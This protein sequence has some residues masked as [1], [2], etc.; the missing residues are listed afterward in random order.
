MVSLTDKWIDK[1]GLALYDTIDS[2]H[3][4]AHRL[5]SSGKCQSNM[6]ICAQSQAQGIGR[7]AN[8]WISPIGGIYLSLL[9]IDKY[10]IRNIH[11]LPQYLSDNVIDTIKNILPCHLQNDIRFKAPNDVYW[12]EKKIAGI[13]ID[14]NIKGQ[15]MNGL[16]I[17]IG[18]N[19][20]ATPQISS[21]QYL[22]TSIHDI[23]GNKVNVENTM[24]DL[25]ESIHQTM[26]NELAEL[27]HA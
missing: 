4:E 2:T 19:I 15:Y 14:G 10:N 20:N 12:Q 6:I 27:L 16:I 9:Y 5:L 23:T 22:A 18:M 11:L 26:Y 25:I 7:Q 17:S 24:Y 8:Q 3:A 1:Y 13:L 21:N